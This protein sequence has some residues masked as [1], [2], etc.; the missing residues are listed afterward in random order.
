[1]AKKKKGKNGAPKRTASRKKVP[2]GAGTREQADLPVSCL[3]NAGLP[4][5][6]DGQAVYPLEPV[7]GWPVQAVERVE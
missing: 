3:P 5:N 6:V 4:L 2:A 1:M 7:H